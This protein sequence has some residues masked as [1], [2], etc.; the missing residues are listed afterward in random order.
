MCAHPARARAQPALA[1]AS[2]APRVLLFVRKTAGVLVEALR[3]R[4]VDGVAQTT[5]A[6]AFAASARARLAAPAPA[7]ALEGAASRFAGAVVA[8]R[9]G[10]VARLVAAGRDAAAAAFAGRDTDTLGC[11]VEAFIV[12]RRPEALRELRVRSPGACAS[13]EEWATALAA[14]AGA[15]EGAAAAAWPGLQATSRA[16]AAAARAVALATDCED[17]PRSALCDEAVVDVSS[18]AGMRVLATHLRE[19][20]EAGAAG[21]GPTL[22]GL[23]CEWRPCRAP[24]AAGGHREWPVS[25]LQLALPGAVYLVDLRGGVPRG[26]AGPHGS[27]RRRGPGPWLRRRGRR[28]RRV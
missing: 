11:V 17:A 18:D 10:V 13:D 7:P 21:A 26:L 3:A 5:A 14:A 4:F 19:A 20:A 16:L 25:L 2:K 15:S 24:L 23:D 28:R 22:V 9:R 12:A 6:E 1:G 8:S 27:P